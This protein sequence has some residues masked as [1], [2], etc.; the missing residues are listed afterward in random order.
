MLAKLCP[1]GVIGV[2]GLANRFAKAM[3]YPA[4]ASFFQTVSPGL[5][6]MPA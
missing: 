2:Y 5:L 4:G 1:I 6:P 3:A